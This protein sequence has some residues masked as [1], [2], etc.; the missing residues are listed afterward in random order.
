MQCSKVAAPLH[1]YSNAAIAR[2]SSAWTM[3]RRE[4]YLKV[5]FRANN[6]SGQPGVLGTVKASKIIQDM[7]LYHN[8]EVR[9]GLPDRSSALHHPTSSESVIDR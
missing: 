7:Y 8:Y 9:R 2:Q 4:G 6:L 3:Q 1:M 5:G